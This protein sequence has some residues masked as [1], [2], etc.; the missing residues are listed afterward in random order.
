MSPDALASA[1]RAACRA[2]LDALK[3]G[4]VH[5]FS[6]GHGMVVAQF[7]AAADAAAPFLADPARP[8]GARIEGA[9]LASLA[10]AG[11]NTNLGIVLL[12]AP[13][14]AAAQAGGALRTALAQVL[15]GTTIADAA[16]AFRAI[17]AAN[18]GGLGRADAH[19]VAAA[20]AITL[21]AAMAAA[22]GRDRIARQY[23]TDFA[24]L[25][26]IG[27]PRFD[28]AASAARAEAVHMAFLAAFPDS[29]IGRKFGP[30]RA[31]AVQLEAQAV[32]RAVD[33]S[34]PDTQRR[35]PL[36][37]FDASL[38]ARGLNPGTTADLTVATLF[39][40]ELSR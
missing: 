33:W 6:D 27:L 1:F 3:P 10:A 14:A 37:I 29:H 23:I 30:E 39:A 25:F 35:V 9:V 2:E 15:A 5:R 40:A 17:A 21:R 34:A 12:C 31:E 32:N 7:E 4:N 16:A 13:L 36:A 26:E 38:K 19:D 20:P 22:A 28:E 11:C 24:D 8:L 18:P